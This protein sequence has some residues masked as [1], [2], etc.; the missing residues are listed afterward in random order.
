MSE[1]KKEHPAKKERLHAR[2]RHRER[3]DFKVL[4][5]Y[6]P[7]LEQFVTENKYGDPTIDFFD[8][9]AVKTLNKT[10]LIHY[11]GLTYW[12]IPSGYLC[13]PI[14]G[15]AD[16]IHHIADLLGE[17]NSGKIPGGNNIKCLDIGVGAN[18]VYPIIGNY[19]YGWSF[20]GSD[21]DPIAIANANKIIE[22]NSKL[23]RRIECRLQANSKDVFFG[24]LKKNE[25]IDVSICN[26]PFHASLAESQ[27]G[28]L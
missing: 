17:S 14:P 10:L 7:E 16:Y 4:I 13:P 22:S 3:Y 15:R 26:P 1:K 9:E 21:I 11:Y 28:T 8:P 5:D 2:N 23:K 19:E 27:A 12:D 24:I 20:V 6:C 25:K 18:C